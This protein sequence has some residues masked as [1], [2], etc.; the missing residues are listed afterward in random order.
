[1]NNFFMKL[2]KQNVV[3]VHEF[4]HFTKKIV[5]TTYVVGILALIVWVTFI[6]NLYLKSETANFSAR[7]H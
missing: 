5:C 7:F 1:M 3:C 6:K 4:S 2:K